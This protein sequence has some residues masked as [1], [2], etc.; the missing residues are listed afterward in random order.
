MEYDDDEELA[1]EELLNRAE[2]Y[3]KETL[4]RAVLGKMA[5]DWLLG[6]VGQFIINKVEQDTQEAIAKLINSDPH[7]FKQVQAAQNDIKVCEMFK[8]YLKQLIEE[9]AL[10]VQSLKR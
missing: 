6:D 2:K 8:V 10:A 5:E 1:Q 7:D 3:D 4:E 9:G